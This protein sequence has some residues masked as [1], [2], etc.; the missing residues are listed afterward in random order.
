[1]SR[2]GKL[3]IVVPGKVE[4]TLKGREVLVKGPLGSLSQTIS[5]DIKVEL[6]DGIISCTPVRDD[7]ALSAQWGLYRVLINNMVTG[8]SVGFKKVMTMIGVGYRA[9]LMGKDLVINIGLSHPV[10]VC[11]PQG[12]TFA[13]EGPTKIIVSGID[14][15]AVG[16]VAAEI[17]KT[18]PPEP[19]KGKGIRYEGEEVHRK[20]GKTGVK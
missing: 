10:R 2:I 14:K 19:Y 15:Q 16:Q 13:V 3:P 1:L 18:R 12:I 7:S 9:E 6:N 4:V 11:P 20:A 5:D 17:R 8:V